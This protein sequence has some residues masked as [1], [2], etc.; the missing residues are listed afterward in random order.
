[1]LNKLL[2]SLNITS[3]AIIIAGLGLLLGCG[4][5]GAEPALWVA[6]G[7]HATVYLFGTI[8]VLPR[9][10]VWKSPTIAT[11]L[12]SSG[13]LWLEVAHPNDVH[14][15]QALVRETGLDP[16]HPLSTKLTPADLARV[17]AAAKA[18]GIPAGEAA[19]EPMRPWLVSATLAQALLAQAGYDPESG[20]EQTLLRD[21][22]MRGKPVH[23]FETMEQQIHFFADM[24]PTLEVSVLQSMLQDYD[25]GLEKL[26]AIIDAWMEGDAKAIAHLVVDEVKGPYPQLYRT[27]FV[28]RNEHWADAIKSMLKG[29]G[30]HFIAVGA[31]H[32]A[33]ED[34]LQNELKRRGVTVER[35]VPRD[36]PGGDQA[37][38][39]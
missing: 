2:K 29:A 13:E 10:Q 35:V 9:E 32:L 6:K 7:P 31:G 25:H 16:L 24:T 17:E 12:A 22:A 20:V 11:A 15:A 39:R 27:I 34:S 3:T 30:V 18:L 37:A 21:E 28:Q 38:N 23:G 14:A 5:A 33:G 1:M 26:D 8:H 4:P 36:Q 19:L